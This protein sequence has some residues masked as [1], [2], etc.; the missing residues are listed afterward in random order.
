MSSTLG[1]ELTLKKKKEKKKVRENTGGQQDNRQGGW[2]LEW[3][4]R[5]QWAFRQTELGRALFMTL[6]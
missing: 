1:L 6:S 2:V 5:R 3:G 4:L